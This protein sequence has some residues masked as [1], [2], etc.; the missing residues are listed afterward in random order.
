MYYS[1][2]YTW[3]DIAG[4]LLAYGVDPNIVSPDIVIRHLDAPSPERCA[5][6]IAYEVNY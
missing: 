2:G 5:A 3:A 6:D 4:E 1:E